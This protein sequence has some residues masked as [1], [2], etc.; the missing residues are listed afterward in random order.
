L[1]KPETPEIRGEVTRAEVVYY[2][3]FNY[4]TS[5]KWL[6]STMKAES[7]QSGADSQGRAELAESIALE[8]SRLARIASSNDFPFLAQLI[9]MVVAEAWREAT[10]PDGAGEEFR[11]VAE[12]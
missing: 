6:R 4:E 5:T 1:G 3:K 11:D 7:S 9:D 2:Q 12:S 8:A 10:E